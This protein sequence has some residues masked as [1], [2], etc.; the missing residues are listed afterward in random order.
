MTSFNRFH[1]LFFASLV[2]IF[3]FSPAYTFGQEDPFGKFVKEIKFEGL[4]NLPLRKATT[5]VTGFRGKKLDPVMPDAIQRRLEVSGY[6]SEVQIYVDTITGNSVILSAVV[7][8]NP[9][10]GDIKIQGAQLINVM[11]EMNIKKGEPFSEISLRDSE[12]K[13]KEAYVKKGYLKAEI[14][15][16]QTTSNT[17]F[18]TINVAVNEG[19]PEIVDELAFEGVQKLTADPKNKGKIKDLE[20]RLSQEK[21]GFAKKGF[22][23]ADSIS[24][25]REALVAYYASQGFVDAKV[26]DV[27]VERTTSEKDRVIYIKMVYVIDEGDEWKYGGINISGNK[28]FDTQELSIFFNS[29]KQGD[30]VDRTAVERAFVEG[31]Q[32]L[33]LNDG[34]IYNSYDVKEDRNNETK[35]IVFNFNITEFDRAYVEGISISGNTKTKDHVIM[36]E[37]DIKTGDVY[38]YE[39]FLQSYKNLMSTGYFA[40][41]TPNVTP[42]SLPGL[43]GLSFTV[44]EGKTAQVMF[45]LTI[46]GSYESFPVSG[47]LTLSESN[48][49]GY[50]YDT[51]IEA[52]ANQD[53]ASVRVSFY[54]PRIN[55]T[56]WGLGGSIAYEFNRFST[57]QD[58][59]FPTFDT[60]DIPDPYTGA[61]VYTSGANAG[62][63]FIDPTTGR[64]DPTADEIRDLG[65]MR[66]YEYYGFDDAFSM[67]YFSHRFVGSIM[68]GYVHPLP[69]GFLR[70]NTGFEIGFDFISYDAAA[71]RPAYKE[72]RDGLDRWVFNDGLWLKVAWDARDNPSNPQNGFI[73]SQRFYLAGGVL[74]GN[75]TYLQSQTR[76]DYHYAFPKIRFSNDENAWSMDWHFKFHTAFSWLGDQFGMGIR[77]A[78][79][80][81][82]VLDGMFIGPG[83]SD[84]SDPDGRVLWE[85]RVQFSM[86]IFRTLLYWDTFVDFVF[87]WDDEKS[88]GTPSN[89]YNFFYGSIATGLRVGIPSFPMGIYLVKRFRFNEPGSKEW[90]N[91]SPERNAT[92][93]DAGLDI[94]IVFS[95]DM[96]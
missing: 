89:W 64:T 92:F 40:S 8:E 87:L 60:E 56:R 52:Q 43:V 36:R 55:N 83:W 66:D 58:I 88:L 70:F 32:S 29:F 33:Y 78:K 25:D 68:T 69:Y 28:V 45:G 63:Y 49:L 3:L 11:S 15:I 2:F 79:R 17:G 67:N 1:Y 12:T 18:V 62:Q 54:D 39:N 93:K 82:F 31:L 53:Q 51:R 38:S 22:F 86:D 59:M 91:W 61:Y 47:M 34:Y 85:S 6:F 72:I 71:F 4:V 46:G 48:F 76:L 35:E 90:I 21:R 77:N 24:V 9:I 14:K 30:V 65:L 26:T 7:K 41:V 50:G 16:S 57:P 5:L 95:V 75:R 73:L 80:N 20:K 13:L 81:Y 74:G 27:R 94:A 84:Y 19:M 10:V 37:M 44:E 23:N 96:Y 42:G